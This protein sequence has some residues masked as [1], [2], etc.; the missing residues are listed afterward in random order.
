MKPD[1]ATL[2]GFNYDWGYF[3]PLSLF[4]PRRARL[5]Y[6]ESRTPIP[7]SRLRKSDILLT[8]VLISLRLCR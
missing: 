6:G 8:L 2:E 7:I 1:D 5:G 4:R 3:A